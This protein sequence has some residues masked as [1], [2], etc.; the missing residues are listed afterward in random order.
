MEAW[1]AVLPHGEV[2]CCFQHGAD[3]TCTCTCLFVSI[4]LAC[5]LLQYSIASYMYMHSSSQY[6]GGTSICTVEISTYRIH[7]H[8]VKMGQWKTDCTKWDSI[9]CTT[10]YACTCIYKIGEG[11]IL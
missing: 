11:S 5:L 6:K 9:A 7:V 1:I 4:L 3:C 8:L 10:M 2:V